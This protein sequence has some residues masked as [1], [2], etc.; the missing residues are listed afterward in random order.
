M[1]IFWLGPLIG[2]SNRAEG[3]KNHNFRS[4]CRFIAKWYE[5]GP[6]NA[7]ENSDA[8]YRMVLFPITLSDFAKYSVTRSARGLCATAEFLVCFWSGAVEQA[9]CLSA[10]DRTSCIVH[11][12]YRVCTSTQ[13]NG[14]RLTPYGDRDY[15]S[16]QYCR[17]PLSCPSVHW[18][19]IYRPWLM[20]W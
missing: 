15:P 13:R 16:M 1:A 5:I 19:L 11:V 7:N 18:C 6:W 17:C 12:H 9:A 20:K 14:P 3:L 2:A 10:F 8:I 4:I